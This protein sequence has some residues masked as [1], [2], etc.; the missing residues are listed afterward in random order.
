M[1]FDYML[2]DVKGEACVCEYFWEY[3]NSIRKQTENS[4]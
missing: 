2:K 3:K 4:S 1:T